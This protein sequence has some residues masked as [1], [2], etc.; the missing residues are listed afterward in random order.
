MDCLEMFGAT[1]PLQVWDFMQSLLRLET[2]NHHQK[3]SKH[4]QQDTIW[5]NHIQ[6]YITYNHIIYI[7]YYIYI[8]HNITWYKISSSLKSEAGGQWQGAQICGL[9]A[10]APPRLPFLVP[11]FR[12]PG[13]WERCRSP[14]CRKP[15]R[16]WRKWMESLRLKSWHPTSSDQTDNTHR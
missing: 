6:W 9:A 12:W 7:W 11:L 8:H 10:A 14:G 16:C 1:A 15:P 5:H 4:K 3:L 2:P 13:G